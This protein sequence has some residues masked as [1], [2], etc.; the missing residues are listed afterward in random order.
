MKKKSRSSNKTNKR[1]KSGKISKIFKNSKYQSK[2]KLDI[3]SKKMIERESLKKTEKEIRNKKDKLLK[4]YKLEFQMRLISNR[5][6]HEKNKILFINITLK[7][8]RDIINRDSFKEIESNL[9][10]CVI[11]LMKKAIYQSEMILKSL[12]QKKNYFNIDFFKEY[13][14]SKNHLEMIKE[15]MEDCLSSRNYF[16]IFIDRIRYKNLSLYTEL[17]EHIQFLENSDNIQPEK[18]SKMLKAQFSTLIIYTPF[19]KKRKTSNEKKSL[20]DNKSDNESL[21][22][23]KTLKKSKEFSKKEKKKLETD[24][25]RILV[26]LKYCLLYTSPSPRDG[27]LSRM[28]SSA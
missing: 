17:E 5:Y 25:Y 12:Q 18:I 24:F 10:I 11:F 27:L 4:K 22:S 23:G 8:I 1:K 9:Y 14:D 13:T 6:F 26:Q 21:S 3:Q 19:K 16:S 28:P 2:K 15:Y 7:N 20:I